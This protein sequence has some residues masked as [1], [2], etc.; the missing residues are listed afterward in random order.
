V[1]A[2]NPQAAVEFGYRVVAKRK[3]LKAGRLEKVEKPPKIEE[4]VRKK[5][6]PEIRE[7]AAPSAGA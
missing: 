3:D 1:W 5:R 6:L 7:A 4:E 2:R